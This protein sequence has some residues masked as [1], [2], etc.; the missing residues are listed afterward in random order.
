MRA[1]TAQTAFY[2]P[3]ATTSAASYNWAG[4]V[5]DDGY[6]T[7]VSAT[8]QVPQVEAQQTLA[9]EATWVGIGGVDTND[10]IQA[11]TQSMTENGRVEYQAWY[12]M[13]PDVSKTV[14]LD[15]APGDSITVAL[16]EMAINRW[17]ILFVDNTT[18]K[19]HA[20]TVDYR[21]SHASADWVEESPLIAGWRR[22]GLLPLVNFGSVVFRTASA[23]KDGTA[24][25]PQ[26]A[27]AAPLSLYSR[28]GSTLAAPSIFG[29]DGASFSVTRVVSARPS[30]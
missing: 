9:G 24:T 25:T 16:T 12:E 7:A 19:Q 18:G 15:V 22:L 5:A 4:Y 13:L 11:G 6:Y 14:A 10:L 21:S 26:S 17:Q 30:V 8:W 29:D 3:L 28:R 2:A 23:V 1:E 27:G 20:F